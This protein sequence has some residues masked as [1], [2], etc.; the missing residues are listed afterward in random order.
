MLTAAIDGERAET[1][2]STAVLD[3]G[4]VIV[5]IELHLVGAG[6]IMQSLQIGGERGRQRIKVYCRAWVRPN[7]IAG[8]AGQ[9]FK[10]V[11]ELDHA[12]GFETLA[13]VGITGSAIFI[14]AKSA[15]GELTI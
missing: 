7:R 8:N 2:H 15:T 10:A 5:A 11:H 12:A 6:Q 1:E 4:G 14:A 9:H 13:R 3:P